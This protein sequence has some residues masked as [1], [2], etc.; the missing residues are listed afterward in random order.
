[1]A[2]NALKEAGVPVAHYQTRLDGEDWKEQEAV[3]V[4]SL[5]SAKGHEY[6]AVFIVGMVDGVF[7][8]RGLSSADIDQERALLFVGVTRARDIV[9]LSYSQSDGSGRR[10]ERSRFLRELTTS[11]DSLVFRQ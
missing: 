4:S 7:P 5:H 6:A 2:H 8:A 10:L 3:R 9:Y 1:M 11:C